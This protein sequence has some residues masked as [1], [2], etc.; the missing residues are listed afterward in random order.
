M[1]YIKKQ[2]TPPPNWDVWFTTATSIRT[3]NYKADYDSLTNLIQAKQY[4]ID[5]Q[6]GLCAYC[7]Q[8]ITNENSSIEH[9]IPK[10][11]NIELSTCYYNL[12]AVCKTQLRD[13]TTGKFHCDKEKQSKLISPLI[14]VSN[15][16]VTEIRNSSYFSAWADGTICPKS[17]LEHEQ[18][19]QAE[20]FISVLH[21]NHTLLKASRVKDVLDGIIAASYQIPKLQKRTFWQGQF[22]RILL[23]KNH[24]FRQFLLIFIAGKIGIN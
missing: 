1:Q 10:E 8:T 19:I 11:F 9:I 22:K 7:Q 23:T 4:L 5:E 13:P 21:L 6:H 18:K 3:Y 24:P 15:S 20:A 17:L 12:V 2:N 14:F 16:D